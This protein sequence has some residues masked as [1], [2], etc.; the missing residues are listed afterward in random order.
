[1][2]SFRTST[3]SVS[4]RSSEYSFQSSSKSSIADL[5]YVRNS[6]DAAVYGAIES[7]NN[8]EFHQQ[9][10]HQ[11]ATHYT[12][13]SIME[14]QIA[15]ANSSS[16]TTTAT[17]LSSSSCSESS[18]AGILSSNSSIISNHHHHHN[19]DNHS[20]SY[21]TSTS[22]ENIERST[23]KLFINQLHSMSSLGQTNSLDI[24]SV[25]DPT[26]IVPPALPPK[27]TKCKE[28]H[29]SQYDNNFD[30]V[31]DVHR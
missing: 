5:N 3:Q 11:T 29:L 13:S 27:T 24:L 4:K 1:M 26:D 19:N 6:S 28:R 17:K 20:I 12:T 23:E 7:T 2:N 18:S 21:V 10:H 14:Q 25:D 31:D 22:P 16:S 9:Q 30:E 8:H 15:A